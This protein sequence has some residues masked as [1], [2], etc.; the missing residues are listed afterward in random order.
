MLDDFKKELTSFRLLA[1]LLTI[2]VSIYLLQILWS[3]IQGFSD[4]IIILVL[5]WLL[6][7][8][9][10]P[11]V[12]KLEKISELPKVWAATIVYLFFAVLFTTMVFVFIPIVTSEFVSLS[13]IIPT[14]LS[15]FPK[16]LEA[17]NNTLAKSVEFLIGFIP[18][19]AAIFVDTILIL[20]MSFYLLV[21]KEKIN[22]EIYKLAPKTWH[23]N[24]KFIQK[25][26][27]D[28]FA[29][30]LQIQ[31]IFGVIAGITT[32]IVLRFFSVDFAASV[33]VLSGILTVIPLVGP[34]LALIPPVFV[35]LAINPENITL[36]AIV[37]AVLLLIQQLI[38]NFIGAKLMGR[39]FKLHPVIVFL[40]I[41]IG[42]KLAGPFG[43]V[44]VVPFL[45]IIVIVLKELGHYFINP[46]S[47]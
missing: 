38:F 31:V 24:L 26:I 12:E 32:W 36:A 19:L 27:D 1:I 30:F 43:A 14:F 17:W 15:P 13:K 4:I 6:S 29:S 10:E 7:F 45:G 47:S 11:I 35:V 40:S 33:G 2:A 16:Y 42:Y 39:A 21:D 28:T 34:F 20:F 5:A 22:S 23:T 44:F 18:S 37:F 25:V 41:I 46:E 3:L 8:I 9:F